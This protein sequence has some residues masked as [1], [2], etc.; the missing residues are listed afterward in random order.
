MMHAYF[1]GF[2]LSLVQKWWQLVLFFQV[3]Q[4]QDI[5]TDGG[6][7]ALVENRHDHPVERLFVGGS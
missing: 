6:W 3:A 4:A 7:F 2:Y 5:Q 1:L